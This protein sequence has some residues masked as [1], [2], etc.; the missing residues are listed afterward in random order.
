MFDP[1]I[2]HPSGLETV[3]IYGLVDPETGDIRYIGKSIRP[4]ERVQNHMNEVSN[5]HRSHWL[6]SLKKRDLWPELVILETIVGAWPWQHS[7]RYW[8]AY[9]RKKGWP[10][11]NNTDGGDGVSGLPIETR[12]RMRKVWLGRKHTPEACIK[13]GN[14]KRGLKASDSTR[15]KMSASHK[16]RKITWADKIG[17]KHRKFKAQDV[18]DVLDAFARGE[19]TGDIAKRYGVHR[20]TISKIKMGK[21]TK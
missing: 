2:P 8:I 5:C 18:Q 17:E 7:E 13:I 16:G 4:R 12:E 20:T 19:K 11:T 14:A 10:L 6:Q 21:Y 3:F 1:F 15:A 9:G